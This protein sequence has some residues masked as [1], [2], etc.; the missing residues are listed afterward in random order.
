MMKY[1]YTIVYVPDVA[2]SLAFFEKAFGFK[3]RFLTDEGDYGE[4]DTGGTTLSFASH[5]LAESNSTQGF[6]YC[7]STEKPLGVELAFVTDDVGKAHAKALEAGA[8]EIA[9]PKQK[10]WG[11]SVS[12]L[13]CPD[14]SL[15][16]LCT[17]MG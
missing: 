14:G 12:Y 11:Q 10:P 2:A 16:E 3:R 6:V 17:A 13:R 1:A 9:S 7:S 15:V 4:L 8:T 5:E